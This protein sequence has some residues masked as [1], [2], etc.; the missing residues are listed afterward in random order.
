[1][2]TTLEILSVFARLGAT[3]FG[4]PAA[5]IALFE[6]EFVR[7]RRWL[8]REEFLALNAAAQLI[9]GPNSTELA[10]HNGHRRGGWKGLVAAGAGFILPAALLTLLVAWAYVRYGSLPAVQ[11]ALAGIKL[12]VM[13]IV[14]RA[15]WDFGRTALTTRTHALVATVAGLAVAS[16]VNELFVL[17]GGGLVIWGISSRSIGGPIAPAVLPALTLFTPDPSPLSLFASFA[18]IGAVLFGSGY[19]LYAFLHAEFVE[20]LGWLSTA[21]VTDAIAAGQITPGPLFST[22]T[23]VGYLVLGWK[24]A[25]IATAGIFLPAFTFVALSAPLLPLIERHPGLRAARDGVVAA[26]LG[27]LTVTAVALAKDALT[28]PWLLSVTVRA[29]AAFALLRWKLSPAL[30]VLG[31]ALFGTLLG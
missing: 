1:M 10:I 16:G 5:H 26:S 3:T 2:S 30:L 9:P 6:D 12:A 24:G 17:L 15:I 4:G 27:L 13:V 21:Q 23:F 11:P 29:S 8:T 7:R 22:A 19:V 20:R 25:A 14:A 18:K 31:G 28:A